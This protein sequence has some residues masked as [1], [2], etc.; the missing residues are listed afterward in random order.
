LAGDTCFE[1]H[2]QY[3]NDATGP[4]ANVRYV[5]TGAIGGLNPW[6]SQSLARQQQTL[7]KSSDRL[8]SQ[9]FGVVEAWPDW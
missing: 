5:A 1:I 8:N 4:A 3:G 9:H 7:S 6:I 2:W